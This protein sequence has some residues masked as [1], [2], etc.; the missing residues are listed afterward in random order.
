MRR[1]PTFLFAGLLLIAAAC[2]SQL[3]DLEGSGT[4]LPNEPVDR[5][6]SSTTFAATTTSEV[7]VF[8]P[9]ELRALQTRPISIIDGD[10]TYVLT[11]A[12]A[13]TGE[14]RTQGLMNVADLGDLDGMLFVWDEPTTTTFW[15][16]DTI[17][18]LDIAF[19]DGNFALVDSF[20]MVPCTEDSCPHY[21][22]AGPFSYAIE[23]PGT[24]FAALTPAASLVL[25]Q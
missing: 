13:D 8:V 11:V 17:L 21:Q 19:F 1:T 25:E 10:I 6:G 2:S 24:G 20:L 4:E 16:K 12:V 23:V 14:A 5:A 3:P 22:A 7:L 9:E 15:K 18:P